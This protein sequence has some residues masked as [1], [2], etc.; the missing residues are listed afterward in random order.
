MMDNR[1]F[2]VNGESKVMLLKTLELVLMQC[3]GGG[4]FKGWYFDKEKGLV[5]TWHKHERANQFLCPDGLNATQITDMI[6]EWLDSE[7]A[8]SMKLTNW[9]VN[10]DHDGHNGLGWRVYCEGWGEN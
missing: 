8:K 4:R 5:L 2:N 9:D 3:G 10:E 6:F 1:V 7:D